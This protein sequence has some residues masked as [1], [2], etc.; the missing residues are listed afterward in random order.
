[1]MTAVNSG[2]MVI[3]CRRAL[4]R[5]LYDELLLQLQQ[6]QC[7]SQQIL[8]PEVWELTPESMPIYESIKDDLKALG[9]QL[10]PI[11]ACAFSISGIPAILTS[12]PNIPRVL[13]TLLSIAREEQ[14]NLKQQLYEPIVAELAATQAQQTRIGESQEELRQIQTK[15]FGSTMPNISPKGRNIITTLSDSEITK[16]FD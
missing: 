1:M 3:D 16:L 15:L 11:A 7:V 5:I 9:F 6:Q 10:S 2:L 13:N 8:F 14:K 4:E 12:V